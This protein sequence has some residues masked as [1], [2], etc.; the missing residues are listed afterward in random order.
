MVIDT[1]KSENPVKLL[2]ILWANLRLARVVYAFT[3]E[4]LRFFTLR[5]TKCRILVPL[6]VGNLSALVVKKK[7]YATCSSNHSL[8][9]TALVCSML[10]RSAARKFFSNKLVSSNLRVKR[11]SAR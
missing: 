4:A 2:R 7:H 1:E 6:S 5:G 10:L 8:S 9:A 3:T 11:S